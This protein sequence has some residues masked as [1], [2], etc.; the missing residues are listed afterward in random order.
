MT[1]TTWTCPKCQMVLHG[2]DA[3]PEK[4]HGWISVRNGPGVAGAYPFVNCTNATDEDV[5]EYRT[6]KE[7][8]QRRNAEA[9]RA[10]QQG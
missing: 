4:E 7:E 6:A 3:G 1:E 10:Q 5:A 8:L 2:P 9:I